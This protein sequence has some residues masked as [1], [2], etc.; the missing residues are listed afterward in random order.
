MDTKI[1]VIT[2]PYY[3]VGLCS[4]FNYEPE[5]I[6]RSRLFVFKA[7]MSRIPTLVRPIVCILF[8]PFL[9]GCPDLSQVQ[10]LAKTADGAKSSITAIAADFKG[11][12]DRQN[13]YVHLLPGPPQNPPPPKACINGDDL[14][15]LGNNLVTEQN[16]LLQ[17]VDTLGTLAGTDASG[18]E[19][20]APT[21]SASFKTAGL[22]ATQQAMAGSA[23]TLASAITKM[24]TAGYREKKILEILKDADPAVTQLTS[25]LADQVATQ[26]DVTP[27]PPG[28]LPAGDG[29]S[30]LQLLRNEEVVL[31]SYYQIPLA[32]DPNSP[33]GVLLNVQY[34]STLDQLKAREDAAMAYRKLM[35][36]I[37]LTHTKLLA[38]AQ[39]GN[40]NK[41][42]V[43]K[44]AKELAQPVS[45][46]INAIAAL[47]QDM[48]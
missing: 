36:S 25:G 17:Y 29:T 48:R 18:F 13:L 2:T 31:N 19:K 22:N 15:R 41:A 30:Y 21:L 6:V 44:I 11:S 14:D 16:T 8:L 46:M 42:S 24:A 5:V 45:D 39:S 40:F 37:G 47:Q 12:C 26:A 35:I 27:P 20:A 32:K 7:S 34:H 43:E 4:K 10:Q 23:S 33:A 28:A 1:D 9:V 3:P 38:G